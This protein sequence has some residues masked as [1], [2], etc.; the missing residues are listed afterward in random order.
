MHLCLKGDFTYF[1]INGISKKQDAVSHSTP[2]AEIVAASF[3]LRKEGLPSTYLW[4]ILLNQGVNEKGERRRWA[5]D[6]SDD[7]NN[8]KGKTKNRVVTLSLIHI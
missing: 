2:E 6:A 4:E 8:D 3:A 5:D 1:P 7:D